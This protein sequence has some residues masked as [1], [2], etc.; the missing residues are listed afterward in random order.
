MTDRSDLD[1]R[2]QMMRDMIDRKKGKKLEISC[3]EVR[4]ECI[5]DSAMLI[6]IIR[7]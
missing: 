4:M 1:I 7:G 2:K 3:E 6:F 5:K